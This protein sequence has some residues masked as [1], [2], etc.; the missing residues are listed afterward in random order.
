MRQQIN[1]AVLE[2]LEEAGKE[3]SD[4]FDPYTDPLL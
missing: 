3:P 2:G 1:Q 4:I